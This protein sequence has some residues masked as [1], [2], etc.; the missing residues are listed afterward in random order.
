MWRQKIS[1]I[2][3]R[4]LLSLNRRIRKQTTKESSWSVSHI[5]SERQLFFFRAKIVNLQPGMTWAIELNNWALILFCLTA[6]GARLHISNTFSEI[7]S[8]SLWDAFTRILLALASKLNS[9]RTTFE[10]YL[11]TFNTSKPKFSSW[12]FK[13]FG[14][15]CVKCLG[16]S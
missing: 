16:K 14:V 11:S 1:A 12:C 5:G 15:K 7:F 2:T 9:L 8:W 6:I 3:P 13:N 4:I 10:W